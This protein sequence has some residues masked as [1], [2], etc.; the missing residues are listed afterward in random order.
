M[1]SRI[2]HGLTLLKKGTKSLLNLKDIYKKS[3]IFKRLTLLMIKILLS[4]AL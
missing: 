2:K 3:E 1:I 4:P